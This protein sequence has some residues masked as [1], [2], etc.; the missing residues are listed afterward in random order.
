MEMLAVVTEAVFVG[1]ATI[2]LRAAP[3]AAGSGRLARARA[4]LQ[5]LAA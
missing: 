4:I 3:P 1:G 2:E 5:E